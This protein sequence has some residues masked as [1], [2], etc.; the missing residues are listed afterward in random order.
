MKMKMI[1]N[2]ISKMDRLLSNGHQLLSHLGHLRA[3]I[4]PG[5]LQQG[6]PID[7]PIC[8]VCRR[9]SEVKPVSNHSNCHSPPR[10]GSNSRNKL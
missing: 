9:S 1:Y 4:G 8:N 6:T 2:K 3:K 10:L 5:T 7:T